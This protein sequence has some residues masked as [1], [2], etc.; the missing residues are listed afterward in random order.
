MRCRPFRLVTSIGVLL[1]TSAL[2]VL[3]Q[4]APQPTF[5]SNSE[6]VLVPV[7]VSDHGGKPLHGLKQENFR[8]ESDRAPQQI[9]VFD[10]V[11]PAS[12]PP[13]A[14]STSAVQRTPPATPHKFSNMPAQ[15]LPQQIL[16]LAIDMVNTPL[17]LQKWAQDQAIKYLQSNPPQQPVA[18]VAFKPSGLREV[19]AATTDTGALIAAISRL[20]ANFT[21]HDSEEAL[22]PHIDRYGRLDTYESL[23]NG[24]DKKNAEEEQQGVA[25]GA[26][27]LLSF[28]QLA[29]AY[30]GI[31]GRKTVLWLTT[32]FPLMQEVTDGPGMV[33]HNSFGGRHLTSELLPEFQ[34][35]FT[36]MNKANVVVYPVDV[37]GLPLDDMWEP[38]QFGALFIHPE[39]SH[40]APSRP[41]L[42]AQDRDSLRE[43]ALRTGGVSCTAGNNLRSC[44]DQ[45]ITESADYYLLGFYVPS[46]DRQV[47]WH[48]LKVSVNVDHGGVR[49][50][51]TYYLR[52]HGPAIKS[53]Q[54]DDLRAAIHAGVEY[55]GIIFSV[56][57]APKQSDP[58]AP[59]PFK[60]TVPA[61]SVL[62]LPGQEKL[63]FD[64]F[65]IPLS[66]SGAVEGANSGVVKLD[67]SRSDTQ[68]AL[69]KG[70]NLI[71]AVPIDSTTA[72]IKIVVRDN[73]T[74]RV[75]SVVFPAAPGTTTA[76]AGTPSPPITS[77]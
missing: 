35:A 75:G 19:Q 28:E 29:W 74:G 39:W 20:R 17:L 12:T 14:N 40:F 6:L 18:V 31:P 51:S 24:L 11:R 54:E 65:A 16:I 56:E 66:R 47:G 26:V 63:S 42:S 61:T 55:T 22:I 5:T 15:G 44:L 3:P 48:K 41:D 77:K 7:A 70:W 49:A 34:R 76:N 2:R 13:T 25:A 53:E 58:K 45:A 8:L 38:S 4:T 52:P 23:M 59:I 36:A 33:G 32:G 62:L 50:R 10:E 9:A 72:A 73:T 60:V 37:K 21:A 68:K 67:M 46:Q 27:T 64:V 43:I 57:T 1:L 69:T 71:D 30:A